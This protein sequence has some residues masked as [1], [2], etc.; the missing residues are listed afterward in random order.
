MKGTSIEIFAGLAKSYERT[1]DIATLYQDRRWK[2]WVA[3][4]LGDGHGKSVLDLGC[5][6]LVLEDRMARTEHRF[7]GVD[8]SPEMTKAGA[9]KRAPNVDLLAIAD[10]EYLPFPDESFDDVVSCYVPKYVDTWKLAGEI[11]RVS[12][13]AANAV[14]YDFAMPRGIASPFL[15]M[16]VRWALR[17]AGWALAASRRGEASTFMNLPWIIEETRWDEELPLAMERNG[18]ETIQTARLTA[19]VSFAYWGRK[20]AVSVYQAGPGR[21]RRDEVGHARKGQGRQNSVS[22]AH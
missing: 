11:A 3:R 8:L 9:G 14:L 16:Y 12:K 18:F 22:L 19:G 6:T 4:R 10:A 20:R 5:G 15:Q 13:P 1:L 21:I 17:A 7:V 2:G